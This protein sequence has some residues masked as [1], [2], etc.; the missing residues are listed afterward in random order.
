M[1]GKAT[2]VKQSVTRTAHRIATEVEKGT[3]RAKRDFCGSVDWAVGSVCGTL[4]YEHLGVF[5]LVVIAFAAHFAILFLW[6][7]FMGAEEV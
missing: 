5:A 3:H 4:A 6:T 7:A 2:E 1:K